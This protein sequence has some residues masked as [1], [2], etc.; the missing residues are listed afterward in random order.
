MG[1]AG[2]GHPANPEKSADM[3]GD[4]YDDVAPPYFFC[5]VGLVCRHPGR[6]VLEGKRFI[7]VS[8]D[9]RMVDFI[10]LHLQVYV[11]AISPDPLEATSRHDDRSARS[12]A[13]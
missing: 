8:N 13:M 7:S 2:R 6:V 12:L 10:R 11:A 9:A 5:R 3:N 1:D 4:K